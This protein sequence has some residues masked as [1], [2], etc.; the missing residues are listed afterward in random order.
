MFTLIELLVVISIIAILAALLLP[1]LQSAREKARFIQC[2]SNQHQIGAAIMLY[3]SD[4]DDYLIYCSWVLGAQFP[5]GD[6]HD[7]PP[8]SGRLGGFGVDW[9]DLLN[10]YLGGNLMTWDDMLGYLNQENDPRAV[11]VLGCPSDRWGDQEAGTAKLSY[12]ANQRVLGTTNWNW[13]EA[14]VYRYSA[15][16]NV[17]NEI[18]GQAKLGFFPDPSGCFTISDA[19]NNDQNSSHQG[20]THGRHTLRLLWKTRLPV[21]KPNYPSPNTAV[22]GPTETGT[23]RIWGPSSF[24][25]ENSIISSSMVMFR[26]TTPS[27]PTAPAAWMR[28]KGSGATPSMTEEPDSLSG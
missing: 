25:R 6:A 24:I 27:I 2:A 18:K 13:A 14:S 11:K 12:A 23:G 15:S 17:Q 9:D 4:H 28:P 1:I 21:W 10:H 22:W 20:S 5:N 16:G 7:V 3:A 19:P 26:L 8:G